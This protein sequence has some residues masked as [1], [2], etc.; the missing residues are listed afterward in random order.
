[1]ESVEIDGQIEGGGEGDL[2]GEEGLVEHWMVVVVVVVINSKAGRWGRRRGSKK[3]G[4]MNC[5]S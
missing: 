4:M 2:E 1:V 5:G 3:E